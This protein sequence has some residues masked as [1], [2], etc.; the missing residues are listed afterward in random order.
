M[1]TFR[2]CIIFFLS[3][4]FQVKAAVKYYVNDG[5]TGGDIYTTAVGAA[6]PGNNG[7]AP[8]TPVNTILAIVNNYVLGANDTVFIDAGTYS[9][10]QIVIAGADAGS[11]AGN[12]VFIGA[13]VLLTNI[14]APAAINSSVFNLTNTSYVTF[15]N[16]YI[17]T[18]NNRECISLNAN[19][20]FCKI[21]NCTLYNPVNAGFSLDL[22]INSASPDFNEVHHCTIN[23]GAFGFRIKSTNASYSPDNNIV[24]DNTILVRN[25]GG[26]AF[27]NNRASNTLFYRNRVTGSSSNPAILLDKPCGGVQIY[28]NYIVNNNAAGQGIYGPAMSGAG[29]LI[30]HNSIYSTAECFIGDNN[31]ALDLTGTIFRDNIFYSISGLCVSVINGLKFQEIDCNLYWH[32]GAGAGKFNGT[33]Y[34]TLAAWKTID[35][36]LRAGF[37][38]D[39]NSLEADPLY[40]SPAAGN[41]DFSSSSPA[42]D[43]GCNVGIT[44]D[45]YLTSRPQNSIVDIGAY[46]YFVPLPV[47]L[48]KF[49]AVCQEDKT[50]ITWNTLSENN[51]GYFTIEKSEDGIH[52]YDLAVISGIGNSNGPQQYKYT[53]DDAPGNF[54]YRLKQTDLNGNYAYSEVIAVQCNA[55]NLQILQDGNDIIIKILAKEQSKLKVSLYTTLAQSLYSSDFIIYPGTSEIRINKNDYP[56]GIYII[57][58]E[59]NSVSVKKKLLLFN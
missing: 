34:A 57:I 38:G 30:R 19:S 40:I 22:T 26:P 12:L 55:D 7:L 15:C 31:V 45:M 51:N 8:N 21:F 58:A 50:L 53:D 54:L 37:N 24:R 11:A 59:G 56:Q 9:N 2:I 42:K 13:G 5:S 52:F 6:F 28:N 44:T 43:A 47:D 4:F 3:F 32:P 17:E 35:H 18:A 10:T 29:I 25:T 41:L 14:I 27:E 16:M 1:K 23:S 49:N 33:T 39:E 46:E 48:T 36:D 20:D